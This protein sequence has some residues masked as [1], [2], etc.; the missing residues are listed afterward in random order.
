M[1]NIHV[2]IKLVEI[3]AIFSLFLTLMW[4]VVTSF[5]GLGRGGDWVF[6]LANKS[7]S[8]QANSEA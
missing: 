5:V 4:P 2:Y 1:I 3:G 8:R 7:F 6:P